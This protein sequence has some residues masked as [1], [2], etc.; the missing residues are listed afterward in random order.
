MVG[1][2][3]A[4]LIPTMYRYVLYAMAAGP[5]ALLVLGQLILPRARRAIQ[6]LFNPIVLELDGELISPEEGT[7]VGRLSGKV[8]NYSYFK[9]R[10]EF[11]IVT[12]RFWLLAA[13]GIV[14][15]GLLRFVMTRRESCVWMA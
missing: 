10:H 12:H 14:S 2:I 15:L 8:L 9:Q 11:T 5:L 1:L 7:P 4:F 13:I 6:V 3:L